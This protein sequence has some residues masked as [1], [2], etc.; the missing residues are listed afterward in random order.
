MTTASEVLELI[1]QKKGLH[2]V[3]EAEANQ[4][5]PYLRYLEYEGY[6][7]LLRYG[8]EGCGFWRA[9]ERGEKA[10]RAVDVQAQ[11]AD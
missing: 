8:G 11:P 3:D 1:V 9:T 10:S 2:I 7:T 5:S 6:I 4:Y